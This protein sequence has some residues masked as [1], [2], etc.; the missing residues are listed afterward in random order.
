MKRQLFALLFALGTMHALARPLAAQTGCESTSGSADIDGTLW[1]TN[2]VIAATS[3]DCVDSLGTS[4]DCFQIIGT[5][6]DQTIALFFAQPPV[7]GQTYPLGGTSDNGAM[8]VGLTGFWVTANPPYTGQVQV[9]TYSPGT[10]V[11]EC[12]FAFDAQSIFPGPDI[13]VTN[14]T[15]V[16][17]LVPVSQRTWSDVKGLYRE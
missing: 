1:T 6:A 8:V 12:T 9:T 16:G 14:G 3:S 5:G 4:Y 13:S 11:I 2:C 10:S 17:R 7:Q 15:F